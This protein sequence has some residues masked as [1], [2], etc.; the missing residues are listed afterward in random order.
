MKI[1]PGYYGLQTNVRS[2]EAFDRMLMEKL[3]LANIKTL[4]T[5]ELVRLAIVTAQPQ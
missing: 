2:A 5:H 3:I 4:E 1:N